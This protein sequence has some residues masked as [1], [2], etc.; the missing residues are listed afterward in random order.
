MR[1]DGGEGPGPPGQD[2]HQRI[3]DVYRTYQGNAYHRTIWSDS[4]ASRRMREQRWRRLHALL[5]RGN[6][7]IGGSWALD[8][9][10][11]ATADATRLGS[12]GTPLK[13]ILAVDLLCERLVQARAANASLLP[14]VGDA[15][16]LPVRTGSLGIVHQSTM[17]SS[18]LDARVR[19]RIFDEIHRVLRPGGV[20]ISYD[21]RY[22]N[23][24]NRN[25]RPVRLKELRR[26]FDGWW[27]ATESITAIPQILRVLAPL[28]AAACRV[29]E[30]LPPLR[31]HRLFVAIKPG[32]LA[33]V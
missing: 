3:R 29:V 22:P 28:S 12:A 30:A 10:S 6:A 7:A 18:V 11:G 8:L 27:Q 25:T 19:A 23:P 13:G 4:A 16:L 9:G 21:T 17:V 14:A 32:P 1:D 31:S 33:G 5:E 15:A 20:F 24:W 2:E 26:S